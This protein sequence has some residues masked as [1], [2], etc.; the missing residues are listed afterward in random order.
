MALK[1]I[2]KELKDI[3][4]D[5]PANVSAGPVSDD[6]FQWQATII[7]PVSIQIDSAYKQ[8]G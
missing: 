8:T 7:G 3:Q 5:P 6:L 4:I 2:Q 1:R